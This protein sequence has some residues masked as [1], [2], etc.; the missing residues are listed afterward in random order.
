MREKGFELNELV[1]VAVG[2]TKC[3]RFEPHAGHIACEMTWSFN[4]F[5]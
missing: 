5:I 4:N 3:R 2:Q 1:R